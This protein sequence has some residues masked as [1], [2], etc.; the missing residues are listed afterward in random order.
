MHRTVAIRAGRKSSKVV[1]QTSVN[2]HGES[3]VPAREYAVL[4]RAG[5]LQ[6]PV[7]YRRSIGLRDRV[8]LEL[9]SDHIGVWPDSEKSAKDGD[10]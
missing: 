5:R 8:R 4:D 7:D 1:R 2:E 9:E 6:I 10:K 3:S